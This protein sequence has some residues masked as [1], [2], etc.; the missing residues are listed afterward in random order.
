MHR[1]RNPQ[2]IINALTRLRGVSDR[3]SG[4][5]KS[6]FRRMF[7]NLDKTG[8]NDLVRQYWHRHNRHTVDLF[9]LERFEPDLLER[10]VEWRGREHLD[11]ALAV[12][13]GVLLLVPHFGDE[14]SMHILMGMAGYPVEVISSRYLGEGEIPRR[15]RLAVGARWNT[16]HFPNE[17]P[18]WMYRALS[19]NR[20][21]HYSPTAYGGPTGI[22]LDMFGVPD[23]VPSTP[24][25][26][27]GRTGCRVIFGSCFVLPGMRF[28]IE[29]EPMEL[30]DDQVWFTESVMRRVERC[31]LEYPE[32]Y[33][34][35]NLV[36]RHRESNT[37]QRTGV[38]PH[39]EEV[40]ERLA[41]PRDEDPE[42]IPDLEKLRT[43]RE[44]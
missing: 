21:L 18:R 11:D 10:A 34:W 22:W 5:L 2:W 6:H 14:R 44:G 36:I 40:L 17:N 27:K 28:R 23:L 29:L 12:G 9:H 3:R 35:K 4:L 1:S 42:N 31:G 13:R 32:Q 8:A 20:I 25:K 30:A 15:S 24:W 41:V 39:R 37:I 38:I 26:L 16:L 7:P 33:D 43:L 19:E